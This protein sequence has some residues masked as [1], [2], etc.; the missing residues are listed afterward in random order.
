VQ[1]CPFNRLK[2]PLFFVTL[3]PMLRSC[4]FWAL[5]GMVGYSLTTLFMKLAIRDGRFTSYVVLVIASGMTTLTA[6]VMLI[7]R[8]DLKGITVS[9]FITPAGFWAF[10]TGAGMAVGVSALFRGLALGPA[11]VVVPIYCMFSAGGAFL[12]LVFLHEPVTVRKILG[13]ALAAVSVY[14][15]AGNSSR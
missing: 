10:A 11:S 9:D 5:V 14:L 8:D 6:V 12:G 4:V 7:L 3:N 15:I 13:I 2:Q 1:L